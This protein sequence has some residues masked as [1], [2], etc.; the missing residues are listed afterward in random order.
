MRH[1]LPGRPTTPTNQTP[2][3][4]GGCM[5]LACWNSEHD[6]PRF[7]V[8]VVSAGS[9]CFQHLPPLFARPCKLL[10]MPEC[11]A[12]TLAGVLKP[13]RFTAPVPG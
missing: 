1:P 9:R 3:D 7:S 5:R 10:T 6:K 11:R 2:L 13:F 12:V 8:G 4:V